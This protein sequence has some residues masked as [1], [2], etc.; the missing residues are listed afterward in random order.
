MLPPDYSIR[1]MQPAV[2]GRI[3]EL[4][5]VVYPHDAPYTPA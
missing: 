5:R 2:Y 1:L 3:G 4:C